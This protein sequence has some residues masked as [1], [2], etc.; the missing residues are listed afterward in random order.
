MS[1]E[2]KVTKPETPDCFV[3]E[4]W[5]QIAA[6]IGVSVRAAQRYVKLRGLKVAKGPANR[7]WAEHGWLKAWKA[8]NTTILG[9][10]GESR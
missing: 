3:Y 4:T 10:N 7:V 2:V 8:K 1:Y 5:E 6:A 9:P